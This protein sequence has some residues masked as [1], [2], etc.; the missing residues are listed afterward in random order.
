MN[1]LN[2][3][4]LAL[5]DYYKELNFSLVG[6]KLSTYFWEIVKVGHNIE[7]RAINAGPVKVLCENATCLEDIITAIE[8]DNNA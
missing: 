3:L 5:N 4:K 8:K 1:D 6:T 7:V 2:L